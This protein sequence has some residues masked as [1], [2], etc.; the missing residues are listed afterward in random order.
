MLKAALSNHRITVLAIAL[1]F[2]AGLSAIQT[3]PRTEDPIIINR[4]GVV[5]SRLPGASAERVEALLARPLEDALREVPEINYIA[6]NSRPG[7]VSILIRLVD[8]ISL[9]QSER[10]FSEMREKLERVRDKLPAKAS[11][12]TLDSDRGYAF[13]WVGAVTWAGKGAPDYIAL[14]RYA[15][16]LGSR[17]NTVAGTE[18]VR[19]YGMP[20][21]EVRVELDPI[22]VASLGMDTLAVAA[23]LGAM[24][25]KVPAGEIRNDLHR[26]SLEVGGAFEQVEGIR[27]VPLVTDDAGNTLELQD[28]ARVVQDVAPRPN[29]IAIVGGK[30]GS[31]IAVRMQSSVRGD[32]WQERVDAVTRQFA[33]ELPRELQLSTLFMQER[34]T[35]VRLAELLS[36]IV[37]GFVLIITVLLFSMGWRSAVMVAMS[38]PLT[39][40][41]ALG[42]F[43][44][45][46]LPIHQM[47]IIGLVV[48]LGI[49][50]DNAIV[51]VDT[52]MRFRR[53]GQAAVASIV[54]TLKH[55]W[56]PL[57]GSTLTTI[58]TFAPI[59]LQGGPVGE[60]VGGIGLAVIF[61]LI[62]S[63][64]ISLFLIG[65]LASRWL[66]A[67]QGRGLEFPAAKTGF[68][69]LLRTA[70]AR[71]LVTVLL[72][73]LLPLTGFYSVNHMSEQ[74]FPTSD[75]D[76]INLEIYLP[77]SASMAAT[78]AATERISELLKDVDGIESLHW[79]IG[80][81]APAV[82]YNQPDNMDGNQNYAQAMLTTR[83][84]RSANALVPQ[85]Q[86]KLDRL[87][88]EAQVVVRRLEQGPPSVAPVQLRIYGPD[89]GQLQIIGDTIRATALTTAGVIHVR[90]SLNQSVPKFWLRSDSV[91]TR[92]ADLSMTELAAKLRA[93]LDGAAA[94]SLLESTEQLPIRVRG[95]DIQQ[96]DLNAVMVLPVVSGRSLNALFG[97]AE[98][99][100]VPAQAVI[101][102][103]DSRRVNDILVFIEDSALAADVLAR[104]KAALVRDGFALPD[105][106]QLE[107]GGEDEGRNDA[108]GN[109]MATVGI[110]VV[111]LIVTVVMAFNSFTLAAVILTVAV[112]AA[113]LGLLS[114]FLSGFPFGFTSIIAL[115]GLIGLAV[116]AAI[117]ILI[118]LQSSD[119]AS[120]GEVG[121]IIAAVQHCTRH[122]A[123]TTATTVFGLVPLIVAGGGFWP[124]FAIVLA[125]GT[126]LTTILSLVF[127]PA[128]YRLLTPVLLRRAAA[129]QVASV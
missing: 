2:V 31:V 103:R 7:G 102:R 36:N 115:M 93:D 33:A 52:V 95:A 26:L 13:T 78:R 21:E 86:S 120:R 81:N 39:I 84:F 57:L 66:H 1:I 29:D 111:M 12:P 82:Y 126:A 17:L 80:R 79:F 54:A 72:V 83:D 110:I 77:V 9:E 59:A 20:E 56:L 129:L 64:L 53:E 113:G 34:Y 88:P 104:L 116:N 38:L 23:R 70:L 112:Q 105:G 4:S 99:E 47:S 124:P 42:C 27:R 125:G 73:S 97:I 45:Y 16:E 61:T 91:Q 106:Y 5:L 118:E 58:L 28:I 107:V 19:L 22:A 121:G 35:Q 15:A 18:L 76:M 101:T 119:A 114:L 94:G 68:N 6:S 65:P 127:V 74:F 30:R 40:L 49:M 48:A 14:G 55:L 69:A 108:V 100:I 63:W 41:F 37:L 71:P 98:A 85:L 117:V 62:G 96:R 123:S 46:G 109:L 51:T 32:S 3:L 25:A 44:F 75:R 122:I 43:R 90:A 24:D 60:F 50:V 89:I 11:M 128:L 10:A 67:N 92:N 87:V 8:D